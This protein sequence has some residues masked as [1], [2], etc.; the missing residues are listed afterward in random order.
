MSPA[1]RAKV[2]APSGSSWM[3]VQGQCTALYASLWRVVRVDARGVAPWLAR[4]PEPDHA[5]VAV[6][7]DVCTCTRTRRCWQDR[8]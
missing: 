6:P 7:V 1:W 3:Q 5:H 2:A 8:R 4:S